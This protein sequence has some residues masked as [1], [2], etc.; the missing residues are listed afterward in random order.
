MAVA[1]WLRERLWRADDWLAELTTLRATPAA[2]SAERIFDLAHATEY[3]DPDRSRALALYLSAWRA[4]HAAAKDRVI[5]LA[6]AL[7]AHMSIAEVAAAERDYLTAATAFIDAGFPEMAVEPLQAL[8]DARPAAASVMSE[9]LRLEGVAALLAIARR[10]RLDADREIDD[11]L[12]RARHATGSAAAS[13]FVHAARIARAAKLEER[14]GAILVEA[15]QVCPDSDELARLVEERL[16]ERNDANELLAFYR[17]RFERAETNTQRAERMRSAGLELIARNLQPGLGLRLLRLGLESAYE[18]LLQVTSHIAAWELLLTHARA[19]DSLDELVPLIV[20]AMTSPLSEDDA[21][22]LARLGLD[23]AW[24]HVGDTLAAE[25]YAAMVTDFVPDHPLAMAF[26]EAVPG[27]PQPTEPVIRF[28]DR[29]QPIP[30]PAPEPKPQTSRVPVIDDRIVKRSVVETAPKPQGATGRMALLTPRPPRMAPREEPAPPVPPRV[31]TLRRDVS[32]I[33]KRK[34][35]TS[36]MSVRAPRKVVPVDVVVELSR[37][38]FFTTV[39]RDLS[40]SGAFI[41][42]KRALDVGSII[43]IEMQL[44]DPDKIAQTTYRVSA[45]IAR[46]TDVGCGVA[47]V[48]ASRELVAAIRATTGDV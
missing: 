43:T 37:G 32:P 3:C 5:E 4:G 24:R 44:P 38:A 29:S 15:G 20:K 42:T 40:T 26:I 33:P 14:R 47:F 13:A 2:T 34:R 35:P 28:T 8:V 25:P 10:T 36:A 11:S 48:D 22:Y 21:L 46:R 19:H 41:V 23:I 17:V 6:S 39:V 30:K 31:K 1:S 9:N 7:R 27:D 12:A 16:F 18:A 45:R